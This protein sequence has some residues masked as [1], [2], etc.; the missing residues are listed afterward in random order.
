MPFRAH[1]GYY[2]V[3]RVQEHSRE[4][5]IRDIRPVSSRFFGAL[6][7]QGGYAAAFCA[8]MGLMAFEPATAFP[9]LPLLALLCLCRRV[10]VSRDI[11]PMRVPQS[12]KGK[13]YG[14]MTPQGSFRRAR[15]MFYIGNDLEANRE[16]WISRDDIL[17]HMLILGTTGSG[18]TETLVSLAFNYLAVGGG[19]LYVDPKAAPKLAVQLYTMCRIM[20]RNDDFLLLS[21]M[22]S[23]AGG[24]SGKSGLTRTPQH[25]SNT[26]NPFAV[27]GA[28]QLTQLLFS[29]MPGDDDSSGNAIFSSNAQT[30]IS[31]LMFVLVEMRDRG[32][33][34]LSIDVIRR[35]LMDTEAI[36]KLALR[37]DLPEKAVLALQ[38]G[39]AT[40]GWDKNLP[41]D[42]QPRAF[43]DQYGYARAYFG[44]ALSL[45]VDNYGR[46]FMT[47]HGEVDAVDVITGRRIYVT[48][49]PSMDKDPKELRS[50]GQI[51]LSSVRNACAVGLGS[52]VQ[53]RLS[54]VL[55]SLP[56][57]ARTPFGVIV[58]EYA[59]IETPGFEILL[60]QGRGLG[61]AVMVAS[62]DFAGI[63]RASEAAAEQIV[64]N[65]KVKIFM[66]QEDPNQTFQLIRS[67]AGR[68]LVMQSGGFSRGSGESYAD[69]PDA[70]LQELDRVSFRDLQKQ[71]EGQ[72]TAFFKGE[73][74]RGRT[75]YANPPLDMNRQIRLVS[76]LKVHE[77]SPDV[78]RARLG[79]I[80]SLERAL[81]CL[82]SG[83][84]TPPAGGGD[85]A[86]LGALTE[87]LDGAGPAA[88][89]KAASLG[90]AAFLA[91]ASLMEDGEE[92]QPEQP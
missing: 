5:V 75:F 23:R 19:L 92:N 78:L 91:A 41:L 25:E 88:G 27:G 70:S 58:D 53:G 82:Y 69:R 42:R 45:L 29:L 15:G 60:T 13:D 77:P 10:A 20:G 35:Y 68:G 66:C 36:T 4:E 34:P 84:N 59:A 2:G 44:R 39:L 72:I 30:L 56:T 8:A 52:R 50:L 26:Q 87:I 54:D 49:I 16:L 9:V 22:V 71:V 14:D 40:V 62:Q 48:L 85:D 63:K 7:G 11:L 67:I 76:H 74:V 79:S 81:A 12:W 73:M 24:P 61:I 1:K 65:C 31:G 37:T 21:Y 89:G 33:I 51:C 64:S 55:G 17:T 57:D 86:C 3:D 6:L 80:A 47:T 83:E 46:I 38:A 43:G 28:N 90:I 18:K 32:E